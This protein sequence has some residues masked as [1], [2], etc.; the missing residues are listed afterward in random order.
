[1]DQ[2]EK[3]FEQRKLLNYEENNWNSQTEAFLQSTHNIQETI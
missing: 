2:V 3:S 1:M